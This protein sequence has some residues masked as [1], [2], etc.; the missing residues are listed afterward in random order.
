[1]DTRS[2]QKRILVSF[3]CLLLCTARGRYFY[4]WK[5]IY[6]YGIYRTVNYFFHAHPRVHRSAE[7]NYTA[8]VSNP[9][10]SIKDTKPNTIPSV[11]S[12]F[13]PLR[14]HLQKPINSVMQFFKSTIV[15]AFA[16]VTFAAAAPGATTLEQRD[17]E[18]K[19]MLQSC[20]A[21]SDCCGDLCLLGVRI[22][23][24]CTTFVNS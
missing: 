16:F 20:A 6:Y 12:T 11:P 24:Y 9:Q 13:L 17:D 1:M 14:S 19:P 7:N 8:S 3:G 4:E 18:C 21:D 22:V 10:T 23:I 5:L 15:L 2:V